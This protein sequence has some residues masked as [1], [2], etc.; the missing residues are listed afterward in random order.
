MKLFN[1]VLIAFWLTFSV[2]VANAYK[3]DSDVLE[4][5]VEVLTSQLFNKWAQ[6][7]KFGWTDMECEILWAKAEQKAKLLLI[8][9]YK[10]EEEEIDKGNNLLIMNNYIQSN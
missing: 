8:R 10:C 3:C 5:H 9:A 1:I 2:S 4:E 6:N 7:P